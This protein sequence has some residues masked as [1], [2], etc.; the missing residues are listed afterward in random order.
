MCCSLTRANL[1][2]AE[3]GFVSSVGVDSYEEQEEPKAKLVFSNSSLDTSRSLHIPDYMPPFPDQ[4][5]YLN[6]AV[7]NS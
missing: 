4:H 5:A 2:V 7:L 1:A 3:V 6:T